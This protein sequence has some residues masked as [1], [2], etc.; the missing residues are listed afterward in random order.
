[1]E[2]KL[3]VHKPKL[4]KSMLF[5]IALTLFYF[6]L[7]AIALS[8]LFFGSGYQI[9]AKTQ[10]LPFTLPVIIPVF[11]YILA[12][13]VRSRLLVQYCMIIN[14]DGVY[15]HK[16]LSSGFIGWEKI[17]NARMVKTEFSRIFIP[18]HDIYG[19]SF[20]V[21]S[22]VTDPRAQLSKE[23]FYDENLQSKIRKHVP[24]KVVEN[25]D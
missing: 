3:K 9:S 14:D 20:N 23:Q 25:N 22:I 2:I 7:N 16:T 12:Y 11:G 8:N 1:M 17:Q 6:W 15:Y 24:L 4:P 18:R 13:F 21:P 5:L 19:L 10:T